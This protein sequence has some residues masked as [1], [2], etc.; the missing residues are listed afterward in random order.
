[1]L[2]GAAFA[3]ALVAAAGA[4]RVDGYSAVA[5][6]GLT[7]MLAFVAWCVASRRYALTLA[8]L[9]LYVTLLDGYVKLKTNN[10][11][12]SAIR[13]VLLYAIVAGA[14]LRLGTGGARLRY[15]PWFA[16]V[17]GFCL[18]VVAQAFHPAN[19]ALDQVLAGL[20]QQLE[21]VPLFFFGWAVL[22]DTKLLRGLALLLVVTAALN[23]A[24]SYVQFNLT[25]EEFATW[26]PGYSERVLGT[27]KFAGAGRF[28]SDDAGQGRTRPFGLGADFGF[29]GTLAM[30][31][32]PSGLALIM[33]MR[34]LAMRA[35]LAVLLGGAV[36]AVVTSQARGLLIGTIV[37]ILAFAALAI[38]SRRAVRAVA[39][40]AIV[41]G[42]AVTAVAALGGGDNR[43]F[44]RYRTIAPDRLLST[45]VQERGLS[46]RAARDY[47]GEYPFG[48]GLARTGPASVVTPNPE[49]LNSESQMTYLIV[50]TGLPGLLLLGLFTALLMAVALTRIRRLRTPE[51]RL[52]LSALAA[53][54]FA[55]AAL[56][57]LAPVTA[58][59]PMA[60]YFWLAAGVL[61]FWVGGRRHPRRA[62]S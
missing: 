57:A 50:E 37:A 21:W 49:R 40:L 51:E 9:L 54:I 44:D 31:A 35:L 2:A 8:V 27:G 11:A 45:G 29:G 19:A 16:W 55:L 22:R 3:I 17:A 48:A 59:T 4:A 25:P 6:L 39:G 58:N 41:A 53:P 1:M 10:P 61:A 12:A 52:L 43:A 60:P 7:A 56:W 47:V 13:D 42:L 20:R 33:L 62:T 34:G 38:T 46:L 26:G 18:V 23:G 24:A 14:L 15:P 5:V 36:V 32:I 30:L 28:F